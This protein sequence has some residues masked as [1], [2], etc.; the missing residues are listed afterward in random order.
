[1]KNKKKLWIGIAVVVVLAL[2]LGSV[3]AVW[4]PKGTAGSKTIVVSVVDTTGK[5]EDFTL[6]TDEEY[7]RGALEEAKLVEG[8]E[9]NYGLFVTA[10]NGIKAD[11]AK[12]EWWC[13]TKGGEML[14]TGVD[15]TPIADGD[16]FEA[17]LTVGY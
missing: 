15:T 13:F 16:Q 17:T 10:V 12:Q 14:A 11:D 8:S 1:M 9:S 6:H 3:Y 4:G 7:L 5:S 2:L